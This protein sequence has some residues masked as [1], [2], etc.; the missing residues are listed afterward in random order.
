MNWTTQ[1]ASFPYPVLKLGKKG[2]SNGPRHAKGCFCVFVHH[3]SMI[4][5]A[6]E[7]WEGMVILFLPVP[8]SLEMG[9]GIQ[10]KPTA[11]LASGRYKGRKLI[12][13]TSTV[14]FWESLF[15]CYLIAEF[16]WFL[17]SCSSV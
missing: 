17:C 2:N 13:W 10:S 16:F 8:L 5:L 7:K 15:L 6:F 3:K 1:P 11:A 9:K 12:K 4:T 14:M